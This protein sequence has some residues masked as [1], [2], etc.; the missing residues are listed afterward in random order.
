[1]FPVI[2][3][4]SIYMAP[5][6]SDQFNLA[7]FNVFFSSIFNFASVVL[8]VCSHDTRQHIITLVPLDCWCSIL[9]CSRWIF[10]FYSS[11]QDTCNILHPSQKKCSFSIQILSTKS[12]ILAC[13]EIHLI[14][15]LSDTKKKLYRKAHGANQILSDATFFF[16][17][18]CIYWGSREPNK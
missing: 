8:L 7:P 4:T 14:K 1:M 6:A 18:I 16:Q 9:I 11:S 2:R 12:A 5:R 15:A 3:S 10:R 17:C 13:S